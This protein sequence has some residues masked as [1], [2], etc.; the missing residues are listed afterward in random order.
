MIITILEQSAAL[1]DLSGMAQTAVYGVG[2]GSTVACK[3]CPSD[4]CTMPAV[5]NMRP[6]LSSFPAKWFLVDRLYV[7]RVTYMLWAKTLNGG[8]NMNQKIVSIGRYH[9]LISERI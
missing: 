7:S 8:I 5:T 2:I 6:S 3:V 4:H 9:L 1:Q